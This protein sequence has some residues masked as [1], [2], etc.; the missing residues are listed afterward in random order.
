M[1]C[2]GALDGDK[3]APIQRA[4]KAHTS[5]ETATTAMTHM[6]ECDNEDESQSIATTAACGMEAHTT[7]GNDD[8]EHDDA[9]KEQ[10]RPKQLS[11]HT[12]AELDRQLGQIGKR[13]G[14]KFQPEGTGGSSSDGGPG[15][16]K[17]KPKAKGMSSRWKDKGNKS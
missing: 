17:E 15:K 8:L 4:L 14:W 16:D 5:N 3:V 7:Q 6:S 12:L 1:M 10:G 11:D 2:E 9:D 13:Y